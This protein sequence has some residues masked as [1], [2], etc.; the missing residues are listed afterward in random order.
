MSCAEKSFLRGLQAL[1]STGNHAIMHG[2][3]PTAPPS[4][5]SL[6]LNAK[7]SSHPMAQMKSWSSFKWPG[8]PGLLGR[9]PSSLIP[10]LLTPPPCFPSPWT[11]WQNGVRV[12][13]VLDSNTCQLSE[14]RRHAEAEK[15]H[16]EA[17]AAFQLHPIAGRWLSPA[18]P[19]FN[20]T[21]ISHKQ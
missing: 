13:N 15:E 1:P 17:G 21:C 2:S 20:R 7:S 14:S 4:P 8:M 11:H 12:Y 5:S 18:S 9:P 3:H 16:S 19:D 10:P 6:V